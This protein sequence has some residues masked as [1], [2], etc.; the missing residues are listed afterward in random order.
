MAV[1]RVGDRFPSY[2]VILVGELLRLGDG[3]WYAVGSVV[4]IV[5]S[6]V[7]V[8]GRVYSKRALKTERRKKF[9]SFSLVWLMHSCSRL[10]TCK[11]V[12]RARGCRLL[13]GIRGGVERGVL[14]AIDLEDLEAE[15]IEQSDAELALLILA[16]GCR[17]AISFRLGTRERLVDPVHVLPW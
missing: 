2:A 14:R 4:C 15:D 9:C 7:L 13:R 10:L 17:A 8:S 6:I 3:S 11:G 1:V 16:A 5:V 12:R